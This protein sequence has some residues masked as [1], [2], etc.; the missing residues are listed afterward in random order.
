MPSLITQSI[1]SQTIKIAKQKTKEG[2]HLTEPIPTILERSNDIFKTS[3]SESD[4][5]LEKSDIVLS[6]KVSPSTKRLDLSQHENISESKQKELLERSVKKA[7]IITGKS[8]TDMWIDTDKRNKDIPIPTGID[9][10]NIEIRKRKQILETSDSLKT[11]QIQSST[12]AEA[13]AQ[14]HKKTTGKSSTNQYSWLMTTISRIINSS[15]PKMRQHK[16][17]FENDTVSAEHNGKWLKHYKWD[18]EKALERQK[19]QC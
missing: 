7:K 4:Q 9:E 11:P 5:S 8:S 1:I 2:H 14:T 12:N 3:P 18:L 17:K 13:I 6:Q 10:K 16:C 15:S 19:E